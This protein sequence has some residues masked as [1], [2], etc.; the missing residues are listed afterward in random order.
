MRTRSRRL[1]TLKFGVAKVGA[2]PVLKGYYVNFKNWVPFV[3]EGGYGPLDEHGVPLVDYEKHSG[4]K[5]GGKQY[6]SVT[7]AQ[8]ALGLFELW[9]ETGS[10]EFSDKFLRM[11]R[12]LE[13]NAQKAGE[14]VAV[15]PAGFDFPVYGL[16]APWIS[17]MAQAQAA[18]VLLRAHQLDKRQTPADLARMALGS[19]LIPAG[20]P[21]GVRCVDADGDVWFEEYVTEPP[22][23]VLNGFIFSL[24][25][26]LDYVRVSSE[27]KLREAWEQGVR[28]LERKLAL[29]DTGYWSRYDLVRDCVASEFYHANV[30]IPLLVAMYAATEN[31]AFLERARRWEGYLRNPLCRLRA[32]Y[33]RLPARALRKLRLP[34]A[35]RR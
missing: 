3:E 24:F 33:H 13:E 12:W 19:F 10:S 9:L 15:W 32:R 34:A 27:R 17:S 25:G 2:G 31:D 11:A 18:S 26:L 5:G 23:H 28:T 8:Y 35:S 4:I 22:P 7:V 20:E 6:F 21:G 30:H 1:K 14:G 29:F 16:R